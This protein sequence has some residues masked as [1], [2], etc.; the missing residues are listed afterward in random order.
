MKLK[1][2]VSHLLF[3]SA[4]MLSRLQACP[5]VVQQ[6]PIRTELDQQIGDD[7]QKGLP[8]I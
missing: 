6:I 8:G 7:P 1:A 4:G 5:L 3:A 2:V